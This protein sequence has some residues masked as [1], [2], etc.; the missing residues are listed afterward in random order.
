MKYCVVIAAGDT[1]KNELSV[2]SGLRVPPAEVIKVKK[3]EIMYLNFG[4]AK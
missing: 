1:I 2:D 3:I 4:S